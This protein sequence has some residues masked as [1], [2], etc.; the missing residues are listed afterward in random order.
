MHKSVVF[1]FSILNI[2][3]K[4]YEIRHKIIDVRLKTLILFAL[5]CFIPNL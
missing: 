4:K 1:F 3:H 2:G 5:F